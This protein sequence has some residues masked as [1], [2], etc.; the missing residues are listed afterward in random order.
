M[1]PLNIS[2]RISYLAYA[3]GLSLSVLIQPVSIQAAP[4]RV[5]THGDAV[6]VS[7]FISSKNQAYL[8]ISVDG[9]LQRVYTEFQGDYKALVVLGEKSNPELVEFSFLDSSKR[10]ATYLL[11]FRTEKGQISPGRRI[12]DSAFLQSLK[13]DAPGFQDWQKRF[14]S[15]PEKPTSSGVFTDASFAD[16][17][18][19][20][21]LTGGGIT[22]RW[23]RDWLCHCRE[24]RVSGL[25]F[26]SAVRCVFDNL[27]TVWDCIESGSWTA[28]CETALQQAQ[29]CMGDEVEE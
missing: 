12:A 21:V 27:C 25:C 6:V 3:L 16:P 18:S 8:E 11:E 7:K 29:A 15:F 4:T 14:S 2:R 22:Y 10:I 1:I 24:G 5:A 9:R 20:D 17:V 13:S 26:P 19:I 28:E 23:M